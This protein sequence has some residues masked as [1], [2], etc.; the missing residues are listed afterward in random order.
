MVKIQKGK[1]KWRNHIVVRVKSCRDHFTHLSLLKIKEGQA[2]NK[3]GKGSVLGLLVGRLF[4]LKNTGLAFETALSLDD[5]VEHRTYV[6][7]TDF[8]V[9]SL[10]NR[11]DEAASLIYVS[12]I[13]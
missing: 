13:I 1:K 8:C 11:H 9:L 6:H 4:G 2:K 3:K 5:H 7:K 10:A 12:V